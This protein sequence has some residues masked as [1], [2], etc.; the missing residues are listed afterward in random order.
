ENCWNGNIYCNFTC[1]I[2]VSDADGSVE[3]NDTVTVYEQ[4][5]QQQQEISTT[6]SFVEDQ[7]IDDYNMLYNISVDEKLDYVTKSIYS[8][9]IVASTSS[10][11]KKGVCV[12][13]RAR[14]RVKGA[15]VRGYRGHYLEPAWPYIAL[16]D[17]LFTTTYM[18]FVQVLN[19]ASRAPKWQTSPSVF[20][21]AEKEEHVSRQSFSF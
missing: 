16:E 17:G 5:M 11:R 2:K 19:I 14:G 1:Q 12:W 15:A 20:Q 3:T 21:G 10:H 18:Y 8:L 4:S 6:F 7:V 13:R 9:R